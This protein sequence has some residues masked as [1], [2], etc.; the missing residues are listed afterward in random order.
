[1]TR[2]APIAILIAAIWAAVTLYLNYGTWKL[3]LTAL[4]YAARS[5][6]AGLTD[7]L[8]DP[9]PLT[10]L[11][12]PPRAWTDWALAEGWADPTFTPYLY[13]PLIA[14]A[15]APVAAHVSAAAFF[16]GA[17]VAFAAATVWMVWL[18]WR[19]LDVR[20]L[21]PAA[22]AAVSFLLLI[23]TAPG[24]MSF[25]FGQPQILVS[26]ITLAA[27][28]ALARGHDLRAGALLALAAAAKLSP[29]LLVVIFVMERRWRALGWFACVGGALGL[30]SLLLAGWPLH[31]EMLTKLALIEERVLLS[32][33]VV[34]LELVLYQLGEL[35]AGGGFF[36]IKTARMVME[37][38]WIT[39]TVR[40]F[41]V[42]A[43]LATWWLTRGLSDRPRIWTRLLAM[44]LITLLANPLGWVHYLI[45][46]IA[47]MPGLFELIDRRAATLATAAFVLPL[48]LPVFM[49]V[50][51][52]PYGSSIQLGLYLAA[53]LALL[54][55][56][57]A[58][59]RHG[60]DH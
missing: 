59:A 10:Y 57:A 24:Y 4:Y 31:A 39:W 1:M 8:Y 44:L 42:A 11:V 13:P 20:R 27:F 33:I 49:A 35:A 26:A 38:A 41:L 46:P 18:S 16:N 56:L 25:W 55:V 5:W 50:A 54:G 9:G 52:V 14:V 28:V 3:D 7:L 32:H 22:W 12:T 43:T 36:D 21:G 60:P 15:L 17:V 58:R 48:S 51:D 34:T 2:Q 6:D 53:C 30:A 19:L 29:A 23:A 47:M 37:P 40:G 45:L